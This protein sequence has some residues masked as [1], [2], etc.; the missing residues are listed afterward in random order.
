M[1]KFLVI[2]YIIKLYARNLFIVSQNFNKKA[3]EQRNSENT[4]NLSKKLFFTPLFQI[5]IFPI[6]QI[7]KS[8][9]SLKMKKV[10]PKSYFFVSLLSDSLQFQTQLITKS[11]TRLGFK[12]LGNH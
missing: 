4:D 3:A 11:E 2:L 10:F 8:L 6:F 12:P 5:P 1:F 7:P 9:K